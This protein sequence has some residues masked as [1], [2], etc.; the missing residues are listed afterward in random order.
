MFKEAQ[1]LA[2]ASDPADGHDNSDELASALASDDDQVKTTT[3]TYR[4]N[5]K[6][7]DCFSTEQLTHAHAR[8]SSCVLNSNESRD[9]SV[10]V[11]P[12]VVPGVKSF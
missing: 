11:T 1:V 6:H 4:D 5:A 7:D 10:S 8:I 3:P 12:C 2:L 9:L